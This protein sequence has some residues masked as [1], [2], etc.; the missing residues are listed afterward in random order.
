MANPDKIALEEHFLDPR[1]EDY[2]GI[3]SK[4]NDI[5]DRAIL[6]N[7][8]TR[9]KDVDAGRLEDMDK[10]G[11]KYAILSYYNGASVQLD[12]DIQRAIIKARQMNDFLAERC[13]AH[14]T[15]FGGWAALPVQDPVEAANELRR[16]VKELGFKGAM[17]NGRTLGEFLDMPKFMPI[18]DAAAELDV[19]IYLHPGASPAEPRG[20][21]EKYESLVNIGWAW[22]VETG[23]HALRIIA[24]GLF[25]RFPS[26]TLVLGHM[27]ELIPFHFGR[28]DQVHG[29]PL[30][31]SYTKH[32]IS[33][34]IRNNV[35]VT[36]SGNLTPETLIATTIAIGTDR[37][38]F[39]TD[40]PV[41]D[42]DVFNTMVEN[43]PLSEGDRKKIFVDNSRRL[44]RL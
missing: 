1:Q 12:Q 14:P 25:D 38:L 43:A 40:Y 2:F 18:W 28:F 21:Y 37:I 36:T 19:P 10:L 30:I 27:G 41:A 20:H 32:S 13:A 39:A 15:R 11:I 7:V 5:V 22:S 24:S 44:F 35:M 16:C 8:R 26:L 4:G 9:L 17:I 29:S 6:A 42:A 33:H 31:K 34:Y 3:L 23:L